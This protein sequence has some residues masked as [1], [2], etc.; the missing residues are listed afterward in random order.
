MDESNT[1]MTADLS[2]P[3]KFGNGNTMILKTGGAYLEGSRTFREEDLLTIRT[4][5]ISMIFREILMD[6]LLHRY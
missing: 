1:N 5:R 4:E 6:F 3:L 2:L